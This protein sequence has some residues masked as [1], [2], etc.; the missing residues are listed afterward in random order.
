MY[1]QFQVIEVRTV[2]NGISKAFDRVWHKGLL[3]KLAKLRI[4]DNFVQ[5]LFVH[6]EAAGSCLN[7]SQTGIQSQLSSPW[8]NTV[9]IIIFNLY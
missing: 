9:S 5:F 1:S 2:F 8:L 4:K 6:M 3:A 7:I